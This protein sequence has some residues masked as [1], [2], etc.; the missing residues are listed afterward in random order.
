MIKLI[1]REYKIT[2]NR[3]GGGAPTRT[4]PPRA[5]TPTCTHARTPTR[6][7]ALISTCTHALPRVR[8]HSH[9]HPRTRT[10]SYIGKAITACNNKHYITPAAIEVKHA[11]YY[12]MHPSTTP[13]A[14]PLHHAP[15]HY[16]MR[17]P[18]TSCAH[19]L[20]HAPIHYIMP[21][22]H[23]TI[24]PST[25]PCGHQ[26][27]H[28]PINPQKTKPKI[29]QRLTPSQTPSQRFGTRE[30]PERFKGIMISFTSFRHY[31]ISFS[32]SLFRSGRR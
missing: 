25:A 6:T 17:P 7:H 8:T 32:L 24:R 31:F 2:Y 12:T 18:T 20:H 11:D 27:H 5:R 21:P 13:C 22:I 10:H 23:Y 19:P 26:P 30:I 16:T 4:H 28:A 3:G 1:F 29:V 15:I 14:H 9:A